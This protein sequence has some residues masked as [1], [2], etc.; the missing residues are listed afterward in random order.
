MGRYFNL[1]YVNLVTSN[2][3]LASII[4]FYF[5]VSYTPFITIPF[6]IPLIGFLLK[7]LVLLFPVYLFITLLVYK[8]KGWATTLVVATLPG[9]LLYFIPIGTL[10]LGLLADT[11][12]LFMLAFFCFFLNMAM[13]DWHI[14]KREEM[15]RRKKMNRGISHRLRNR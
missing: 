10:P 15:L 5:V 12:L 4:T 2:K 1:Y 7:W 11:I 9:Y 13:R 6:I 14:E 3:S 8:R